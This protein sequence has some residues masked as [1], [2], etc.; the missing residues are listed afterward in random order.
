MS[1]SDAPSEFALLF[2]VF[3]AL[4]ALGRDQVAYLLCMVLAGRAAFA[5]FSSGAP[6]AY[7]WARLGALTFGAFIIAAILFVPALLTMQFLGNS[8]RPGIAFGVAA[9]VRSRPSI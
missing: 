6:L 8:N 9:A 7:L 2:G 5:V 1:W 3:A 4:M